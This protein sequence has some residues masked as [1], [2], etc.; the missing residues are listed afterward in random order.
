MHA[1]VEGASRTGL[2]CARASNAVAMPTAVAQRSAA[3]KCAC[4][5]VVGRAAQLEYSVPRRPRGVDHCR[6]RRRTGRISPSRSRKS[7]EPARLRAHATHTCHAACN[8]HLSRR[9][10]RTPVAPRATHTCHGGAASL[11]RSIG[12]A[13]AAR[14]QVRVPAPRPRVEGRVEARRPRAGAALS[15]RASP[16]LAKNM[17][18]GFRRVAKTSSPDFFLTALCFPLLI[19]ARSPSLRCAALRCAALRCAVALPSGTHS[20]VRRELPA[21]HARAQ[22]EQRLR[23]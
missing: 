23:E 21:H 2:R 11:A 9:V 18:T 14:A 13:G 20:G 7:G 6:W 19:R 15:V 10:Q 8:A 17:S 22:R 1:L 4:V 3:R 5:P 12:P 16:P